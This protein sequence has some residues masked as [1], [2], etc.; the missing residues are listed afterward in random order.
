MVKVFQVFG[1]MYLNVDIT[2]LK[3]G[4]VLPKAHGLVRRHGGRYVSPSGG[5]KTML[6][7][8]LLAS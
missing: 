4:N 1:R 7:A 2:V 6:K 5:K 8:F 3:Y